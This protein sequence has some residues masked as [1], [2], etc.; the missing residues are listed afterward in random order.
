MNDTSTAQE[1]ATS[2]P[3][4]TTPGFDE[5][6]TDVIRVNAIKTEVASYLADNDQYCP[7]SVQ[8]KQHLYTTT[9]PAV[10]FVSQSISDAEVRLRLHVTTNCET[11]AF[12]RLLL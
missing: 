4:D 8:W 9:Q 7:C 3:V 10:F 1:T 11:N 6:G 5:N 12:E 2:C